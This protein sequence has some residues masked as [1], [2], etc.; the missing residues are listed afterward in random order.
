MS[1]IN[2][3]AGLALAKKALTY[4]NNQTQQHYEVHK[5]LES[6]ENDA[7]AIYINA[8]GGTEET[9]KIH[10]QQGTGSRSIELKAEEGGIRIDCSGILHLHSNSIENDSIY[11]HGAEG[12]VTIEPNERVIVKGTMQIHGSAT[13]ALYT[14]MSDGLV[15]G[16]SVYTSNS[17]QTSVLKTDT[18]INVNKYLEIYVGSTQYWIPLFATNPAPSD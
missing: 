17:A 15:L 11:I 5:L 10:S 4:V 1:L 3:N 2:Q 8:N 16:D 14:G 13:Q 6:R 12:N 9:V 18:A 7:L